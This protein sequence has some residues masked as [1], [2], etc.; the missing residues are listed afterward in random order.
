MNP[1]KT[2]LTA[3]DYRTCAIEGLTMAET[4]QRLGKSYDAVMAM[5]R[6][7]QITF[8]RARH[9]R[10][11]VEDLKIGIVRVLKKGPRT[12]SDI[13][14]HM[15]LSE[16][17]IRNHICVLERIGFAHIAERID[18]VAIWELRRNT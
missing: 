3:K 10:P 7:H 8:K 14:T 12:I 16:G 6:I 18:R 11:P 17:T 13:A 4:A 9:G 5:A 1:Q 15:G 2:R